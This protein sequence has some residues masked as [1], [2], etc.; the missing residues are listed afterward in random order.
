MAPLASLEGEIGSLFRALW[1]EHG[2]PDEARMVELVAR[3]DVAVAIR[4][5]GKSAA[6]VRRHGPVISSQRLTSSGGGC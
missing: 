5:S 6:R 1:L 2:R 4:P 3:S